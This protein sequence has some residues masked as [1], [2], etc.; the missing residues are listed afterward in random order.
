MRAETELANLVNAMLLQMGVDSTI[1]WI[2]GFMV[3][4]VQ[5]CFKVSFIFEKLGV[6]TP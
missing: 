4:F 3:T 1:Y 5:N 6:L 2:L